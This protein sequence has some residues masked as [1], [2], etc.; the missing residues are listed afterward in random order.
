MEFLNKGAQKVR[1]IENNVKLYK[2]GK[3]TKEQRGAKIAMTGSA[4]VKTAAAAVTHQ[5]KV[6][7]KVLR[8]EETCLT[9]GGETQQ[10]TSKITGTK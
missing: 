1:F 7:M 3:H 6:T 5:Q 4:A 8:Q 10:E 2:V 9:L